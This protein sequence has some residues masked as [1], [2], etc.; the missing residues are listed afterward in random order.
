V[1]VISVPRATPS[2][3]P[4]NDA[5][6]RLF[7]VDASVAERIARE[8]P[9]VV[10]RGVARDVAEPL[11][12]KIASL[13]AGVEVV[14][15]GARPPSIEIAVAPSPPPAARPPA[16]AAPPPPPAAPVV[17]AGIAPARP[18]SALPPPPRP[19]A[20]SPAAI[21]LG[22]VLLVGLGW[23]AFARWLKTAG[24]EKMLG[25]TP[26]QETTRAGRFCLRGEG[27]EDKPTAQ[28]VLV[29]AWRVGCLDDDYRAYLEDLAARHPGDIEVI[30]AGLAI[31]SSHDPR[32]AGRVPAP[33]PDP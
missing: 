1:R 10:K 4:F 8:A 14:A 12:Q 25:N 11:R 30:A 22:A 21:G 19:F 26:T 5:L 20:L 2:G 6:A 17:P 24:D 9:V 18:P 27:L 23:L 16:T 31:P 33:A 7:G 13:G 3:E 15:C 28:H 29:V 32:A